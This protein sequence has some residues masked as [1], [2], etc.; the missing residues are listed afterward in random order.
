MTLPAEH[1]PDT[2]HVEEL[3]SL[4][5]PE[6]RA[7]FLEAEGMLNPD[8][9]KR[10]LDVA[11]RLV[12]NDPGKAR[13]LAELCADLSD[14]AEAPAVEPRANY[15][16][17]MAH[18]LNGEFDEELRLN[19]AAHDGYRALGMNLD[20]LRTNVGKMA[21]LLEVGRYQ[22]SLDAGQVVL[23]ALDGEGGLE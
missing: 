10:L 11:D 13:R 7:V 14:D 17:A 22:E 6:Q 12:N 18:G 9:L 15:I 3:L 1:K 21:A 8:G 16:R 23:D 20:A 19:K 5:T 4:P 2:A